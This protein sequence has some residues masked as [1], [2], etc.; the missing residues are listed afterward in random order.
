MRLTL[1]ATAL[2]ACTPAFAQSVGLVIGNEDYAHVSDVSRADRI[3]DIETAMRRSGMQV[4]VRQ[5]A[6]RDDLFG[7]LGEFGQMAA[8]SDRLLVV[9]SGRFLNTSTETYYLPVDGQAG[10]LATLAAN[11][12]PLSTVMAWLAEAPGKA[13]LVLASDDNDTDFGTYVSAGFGT[14]DVPQGVTIVTGPPRRVQDFLRRALAQPGAPFIEMAEDQDLTVTGYAAD[15]LKLLDMAPADPAPEDDRRTDIRDWRTARDTNTVEAYESYLDKHPSGEFSRMAQSRLEALIDTPEARAERDEQALDLSRDA[16]RD[17]QRD[18]TLLGYNTRGIDGIFGRGT[19]AAVA[20]WQRA[21]NTEP[22]GY[23][24]ADQIARLDAQAERRAL[25]LEAEAEQ[26]RQEQM[27]ADIAFWDETG[28]LGDE[29]GLRAYLNRYPDGEYSEVAKDRLAALEQEKRDEA[30][31]FDRRLWDAARSA[32]TV[33]GYEDYLRRTDQSG[34]F[35]QEARAR[36]AVLE[37]QRRD[38]PETDR[39]AREEQALNLSSRTRRIIESRLK[40][41]GLNPGPVDGVFD[42][43]T[44]RAIRR[45]QSA[46]NMPATGYLSEAVV[47]QLLADSVRQIFR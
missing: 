20:S 22:T 27:A 26:R 9:L 37:D 39:Y 31:E 18:L 41:L 24:T 30:S 35:S 3:T 17:I 19:R 40:G 8:L 2:L 25:E 38:A 21:Q 16:R 42:D 6:T 34:A 14:L 36:I 45:Y 4:V 28:A 10:P 5:D 15:G 7:A 23:V 12:L 44:R 1:F 32:D 29:A 11:A 33:E 46:R 13:V 43:D 47:V